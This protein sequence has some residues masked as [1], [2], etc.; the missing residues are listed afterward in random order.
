MQ[1][2]ENEKTFT[3]D[4]YDETYFVGHIRRYEEGV[5]GNRVAWISKYL[6]DV[7]GKRL[8]DAGCGI[9]FFSEVARGQG[10][11]VVSLDFSAQAL[12][13]YKKRGGGGASLL[14]GSVEELP[15]QNDSFDFAMAID[16]IEHLYKPRT[17]LSE[18]YRVVKPGG[19]V[20]VETDNEST[21][22]TKRGFR[23]VNNWMQA[24]TELG[25]KLAKIRSEI[26]STTLHV[27]TFDYKSLRVALEGAGFTIVQSETFAY[28][29][30]PSRDALLRTPGLRAIS[31]ALGGENCMIFM[32]EKPRS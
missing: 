6:K 25:V 16:V 23:R 22:F 26:T 2:R 18:L 11:R 15:F 8:L 4:D 27:E 3:A 9:G 20:I 31:N 32:A 24:R 30:V 12:R 14:A 17:L 5:Y 10:A 29:P 13:V 19:R 21:W 1:H 28:L 7:G